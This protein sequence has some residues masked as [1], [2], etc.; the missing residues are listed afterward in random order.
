M[1]CDG[2]KM[3]MTLIDLS[4]EIE[5]GMP[6][7]PGDPETRI[8]ALETPDLSAEGWT[9]H[10]IRMSL[11]AGTH[12]EAPAH[13]VPGGKNLADYPLEVFC[14][15]AAA[16]RREEIG[17]CGID[18]PILLVCTGLDPFQEKQ[19][20]TLPQPFTVDEMRWIADRGVRIAGFD[21]M[22]V[23]DIRVHRALQE[24]EILIV[25]SMRGL[26]MVLHRSLKVYL[27]PLRISGGEASPVRA[28]AEIVR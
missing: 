19:G 2:R 18:A 21:V 5:E 25:E 9:I 20:R 3:A 6:V 17:Q 12:I 10:V 16:I 27:F 15:P 1:D 24:R 11:H 14:G 28:V 7:Y 26:E 22:S 13:S 8:G 4:L 23:G